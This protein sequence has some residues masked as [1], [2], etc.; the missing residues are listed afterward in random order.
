[1]ESTTSPNK[2]CHQI[3]QNLMEKVEQGEF[4]EDL[5]HRLNVIPLHLPPLRQRAGDIPLLAEFFLNRI[6]EEIQEPKKQLTN[7]AIDVMQALS[8]KR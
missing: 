8:H 3:S 6:S 7:H 5:Y 4:R 1:M 2:C